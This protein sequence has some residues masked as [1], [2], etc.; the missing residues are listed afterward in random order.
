[1]VMKG[2][3]LLA[4]TC[5]VWI[6]PQTSGFVPAT[7]TVPRSSTNLHVFQNP[8]APKKQDKAAAEPAFEPVT[9]DPDFRVAGVFL[10]AGLLLD[11]I[12][13]IKII[14]GLPVTLLGLLFLVQTTRIRFVFN[15]Q[16]ALELKTGGGNTESGENLVVGGKNEWSCD[17][18]I[19]YDFFPDW[20]DDNPVG[21]ILVY[22]K[23]TQT[24]QESWNEGPGK[25][26]NDPEKIASGVA[27]AGQGKRLGQHSYRK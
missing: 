9:I 17:S 11:T 2:A 23:E 24:P 8:F 14:L 25:L 12:P 19:N 6:C 10:A 26:A 13:Y 7:T 5:M 1:M 18:I 20:V 27:K 21:P 16:N 3:L 15:E 4:V 22:F